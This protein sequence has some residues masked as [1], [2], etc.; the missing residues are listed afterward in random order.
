M[1]LHRSTLAAFGFIL[2]VWPSVQAASPCVVL[3][4]AGDIQQFSTY[5]EFVLQS[6]M[7]G[8]KLLAWSRYIRGTRHQSH[9]NVTGHLPT[10]ETIIKADRVVFNQGATLEFQNLDTE[11][12]AIVART[13]EFNFR[14]R[15]EG[16]S[17]DPQ[18]SDQVRIIRDAG[19]FI[20]APEPASQG[21]SGTSYHDRAPKGHTGARGG[22]GRVGVTGIDGDDKELPCLLLI[23]SKIVFNNVDSELLSDRIVFQLEGIPGGPGG[24]GGVGGRGG[25]GQDGGDASMRWFSCRAIAQEGGDGGTGGRGGDGGK[26]GKGGD[27]GDILFIGNSDAGTRLLSAAVVNRPGIA[28]LGGPPGI[29]G[30]GGK[31]GGPGRRNGRPCGSEQERGSDGSVGRRG[32]PGPGGDPG[33]QGSILIVGLDASEQTDLFDL[34][35]LN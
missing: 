11:F 5:S 1:T 16:I 22:T 4:A 32:D 15:R 6:D 13:F 30:P 28:G 23:A 35:S 19:Y 26:G 12:W 18:P 25:R 31:G 34:L 10:R 9:F 14:L 21:A 2:T 17:T 33:A 3:S 7:V 27:G 24:Q 20:S 29:G 8:S